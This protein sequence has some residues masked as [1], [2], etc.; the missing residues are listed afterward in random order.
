MP[1]IELVS[2]LDFNKSTLKPLYSVMYNLTKRVWVQ[3]SLH[4]L[5]KL[6]G[7]VSMQGSAGTGEDSTSSPDSGGGRKPARV[8]QKRSASIYLDVIE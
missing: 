3:T 7:R 4:K 8:I 1:A 2:I 5:K 6:E